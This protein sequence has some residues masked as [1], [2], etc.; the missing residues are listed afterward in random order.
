MVISVLFFGG[1]A[2]VIG[3]RKAKIEIDAGSAVRDVLDRVVS[4][5]PQLSKGKLLSAVN[6]EYS[7]LDVV[8]KDGDE[9]AIFTPV[10]GG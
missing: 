9:V 5:H 7:D 8:L 6:E 10:S 1:T 4:N 3:S 2:D